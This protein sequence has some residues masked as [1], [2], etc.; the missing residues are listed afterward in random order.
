[1]PYTEFSEGR[2]ALT[3]EWQEFRVLG[4]V[5]EDTPGYV[6]IKAKEP[7]TFFVDDARFEDLASKGVD[8]P[9]R[10][11]NILTGGSFE[12]GVSFGW[13]VRY[14]GPMR[15]AFADPRPRPDDTTAVDGRQSL[16]VDIP[17]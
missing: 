12:A 10:T 5:P 9:P 6:M 3:A 16:R 8:A 7:V 1:E 17:E 13:S 2:V 14:Q 15:H 11:G 4:V